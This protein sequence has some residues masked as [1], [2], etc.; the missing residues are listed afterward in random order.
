[1]PHPLKDGIHDDDKV[2]VVVEKVAVVREVGQIELHPVG[3]PLALDGIHAVQVSRRDKRQLESAVQI[4]IGQ[5][6]ANIILS[7]ARVLNRPD[8]GR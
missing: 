5:K 7:G 3:D 1:V 6:L 8:Q 4:K 2:S